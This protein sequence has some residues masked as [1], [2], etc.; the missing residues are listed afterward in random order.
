MKRFAFVIVLVAAVGVL[1]FLAVACEEDVESL[2]ATLQEDEDPEARWVAADKLG[3]AGDIRALEPLISAL[4][5]DED[6]RVRWNAAGAL[7]DIGDTRAVEPLIG[8]MQSDEGERVRWY[9]AYSLGVIGDARAVEPLIDALEDEYGPVRAH[10]AEA[11][12]KIGDASAVEPLIAALHDEIAD[13]NANEALEAL[14]ALGALEPLLTDFRNRDLEAIAPA[15]YFFIVRAEPGAE[16]VLIELLNS[17]GTV[18]MAEDFLNSDNGR[19]EGA[20]RDWAE[21]HGYT[22]RGVEGGG[23][24]RWG[25]Y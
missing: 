13:S 1:V 2:I 9:A 5:N 6:S 10:A 15:Y 11:L 3:E 24:P 8:A 16:D 14:E 17:H 12:G 7:A 4:Q 19:L 21:R 25:G 22:I 18:E 23:G 20:A